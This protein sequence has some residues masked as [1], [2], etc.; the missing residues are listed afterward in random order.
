[1]AQ[2][3]P[4]LAHVVSCG[5][6][7]SV[8]CPHMDPPPPFHQPQFAAWVSYGICFA[9]LCGTRLIHLLQRPSCI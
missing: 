5:W 2:Q 1:V 9:T 3:M 7:K 8:G 4:Q 6:W